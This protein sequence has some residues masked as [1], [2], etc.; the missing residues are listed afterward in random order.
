MKTVFIGAGRLAVNLAEELY[1]KSTNIVQVYSRTIESAKILAEKVN[2]SFT[3]DIREINKDA[4]LYI[5]S[6]K[7]SVVGDIIKEMPA[8]KGIWVHTSGSLPM[9]IF[10]GYT[11]RYG[12]IYPFQTFS[13]DRKV[14]FKE[15]P[16]FLESNNEEDRNLLQ[17]ISGRISDKVYNLSS[18]KRQYVHLT[19]VFACNFVNHMYAV[20][21]KILQKEGIPYDAILPL[22]DETAAKV[23]VLSP[24]D[25]QTGP[26]VRYDENI[27]NKHLELLDDPALKSIYS[28]ISENIHNYSINKI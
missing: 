8:N 4:D 2:S 1:N 18:E 15:I 21:E 17:D 23:H 10:E 16:I 22:I 5:F 26:A 3:N 19:G 25:A 11:S 7:D 28:L 14:N 9:S 24:E 27:I 20:S 13:K 6:I 12:V